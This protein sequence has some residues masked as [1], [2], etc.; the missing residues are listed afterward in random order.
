MINA[1]ING[2]KVSVP[3][4]SEISNAALGAGIN[5]PT[6]CDDVRLKPCG[7]CRVCLVDVAGLSHPIASCM[8]ELK[9]GMVVETD[10]S[11]LQHARTMNLRMLARKY[12]RAAFENFPDKPFHK[13]ARQYGLTSADFLGEQNLELLDESH[14]YIRVDM[15][16][17]IDCYRCVRIC[18][19]VQGQ[20]V[21]QVVE[22]GQQT[23]IVPDS[24]TTL[25][26]SSCVSCGACV[27]TC[28]TGA[29]EDKSLLEK[30]M[31]TSWTKTV[32]PYCGTGCEINVGERNGSIVQVKPAMDTPVSHGHLCVK[33]RYAFEFVDAP[34]RVTE[35]MIRVDGEWRIVTWE[36]AISYAGKR[37][38][39]ILEQY[40]K[41]SIGVVGSARATNEENYL[42]QKFVRV[43]LE[44]NNVDNCARVCHTPSAAAMKL[45]LGTGAATNSFSDIEL[46][47]TILICG[48]NPTEN[49]PI[50]GERMKQAVLKNGTKLIVIDPRRIELARYADVHL[51]PR[52]GTNV[53][54]LNAIANVIIEEDL[55][56]KNFIKDRVLEFEE[57]RRHVRD[58]TPEKVA[59]ICGVD[60]DLIRLAARTYATQ[61]PS[62]CVHGLGVTEHTQ[63]TEGVMCLVNLG[64][65]TGN[66][67]KRGAGVNPLRGQNNVQGSAQMGCDPGILTG[68]VSIDDGRA[69][70]ESVW[71]VPI[72]KEK[73]LNLMQMIDAAG[74]GKLKALWSIGYDMYLTNANANKTREAL[75]L[76]DLVIIQDLFLN[77][78]AREFGH[79]FLPAASSFEKDGTFMNSERRIQRV[80]QAVPTRGNSRSDWEI[81]K[82]LAE[83]MGKGELFR[84]ASAEEIWDEVRKVWKASAGITY[85]RIE[86]QGL[87]WP[88]ESEEDSGTEILHQETFGKEKHARLR[89][90]PY[91][92]TRET[93]SNDFPFLLTTGR[94]LYQFNAGTM[95]ERTLNSVLRPTDLL[96]LNPV[97]AKKL[98]LDE[99]EPV[100]IESRWGNAT[101]PVSLDENIRTGE[102]FATFHDS[103]V[104]LNRIT[105]RY[106]DRHVQSPEFKVT[107]I[108]I[109]KLSM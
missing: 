102:A 73:G 20:F 92:P 16:Q 71:R 2:K 65:I 84:F 62:M 43:V 10:T 29:L 77:E 41:E 64:L 49:H 94:T 78:T 27:D 6:L 109:E 61:K 66:I 67:G 81:I 89:R 87:Q 58:Y 80:R 108:R 69:T 70:F 82:S 90:I 25:A 98:S 60:A 32:C 35:P 42:T 83:E 54:L 79:V 52:A 11:K 63:G 14:P 8:N 36:E 100:R 5:I 85:A 30:G 23:H 13:L 9:D 28:P 34:D 95:T 31:P 53:P 106:R 76:L 86:Q 33:G 38:R 91:R 68:S 88:C 97:D 50:V 57:F 96:A 22:R 99:G 1:T 103:R 48:A 93:V 17:C 7:A 21:W 45:M 26:E 55:V 3:A 15:S 4:G 51:Q 37:L 72:P 105:S 19:E 75:R 59:D 18:E 46:A 40:G 44:T 101:L 74:E 47:Q 104:F 12:P 56:D 39:E 107:A 24:R